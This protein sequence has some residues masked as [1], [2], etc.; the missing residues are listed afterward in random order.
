MICEISLCAHALIACDE[1]TDQK[2]DGSTNDLPQCDDVIIA[3]GRGW[4][5]GC[6]RCEVAVDSLKMKRIKLVVKRVSA[7][8]MCWLSCKRGQDA[9]WTG[10][11]QAYG[12][13]GVGD[14]CCLSLGRF[15][16][17]FVDAVFALSIMVIPGCGAFF[18]HA[19]S[20]IVGMCC[21]CVQVAH[22]KNQK[23]QQGLYPGFHQ[24]ADV[25]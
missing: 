7:K 17:V 3:Y 23:K 10:V 20:R 19:W 15:Y 2:E 14:E 16:R 11:A 12:L 21:A 5:W 8:Q 25:Y 9:L 1:R 6:D 22:Q 4:N 24:S 18:S 13:T